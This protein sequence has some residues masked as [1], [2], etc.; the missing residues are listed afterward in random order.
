MNQSHNTQNSVNVSTTPP[1]QPLQPKTKWAGG[2][3]KFLEQILEPLDV[4]G[5]RILGDL[6]RTFYLTIQD[7]IALALLLQIPGL[8]GQLITGKNF[9]SF[10]VCLQ[11]NALGVSRYACFIIVISDFLLWIVIAGRALIRF[12]QDLRDLKKN[13]RG[14]GH[15]SGQP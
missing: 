15:G 13:N 2:V 8:L 10:D 6:W 9:S 12:W 5:Q 11:E 3:E 1:Q 7:A 14:T 4:L